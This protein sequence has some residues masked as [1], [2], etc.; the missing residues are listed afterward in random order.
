MKKPIAALLAVLLSVSAHAQGLSGMGVPNTPP[1]PTSFVLMAKSGVASSIT[2]TLTETM[3]ATITIPANVVGANGQ[4]KVNAYWTVTSSANVKN[5]RARLGGIGG[6]AVFGNA[7]TTQ[8]TVLSNTLIINANSTSSQVSFSEVA[9]GTDG[10]VNT[11]ASISSS[12]DM[13]TSQSLV[14]TGQLTNTGETIT[15]VGYSVEYAF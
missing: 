15:L 9:R 7:I 14:I 8:A 13:T 5:I 6:T 2:G 3:L 12:I 4:I 1:T 10:L 11:L